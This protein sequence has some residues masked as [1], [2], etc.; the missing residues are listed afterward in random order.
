MSFG[1]AALIR[2]KSKNCL[3][4]CAILDWRASAFDLLM[5]DGDDLRR[6][7]FRERKLALGKL[8]I[9][10]RGSIQYVEHT[11]GHGAPYIGLPLGSVENLDQN[12]ESASSRRNAS[13]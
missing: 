12:Q 1:M 4:P 5:H 6:W 10:S 11:E 13:D 2:S 3:R 9:R 7:P 8:L